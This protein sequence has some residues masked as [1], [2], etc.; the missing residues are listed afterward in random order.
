M[1]TVKDPEG[2]ASGVGSGDNTSRRSDL[3]AVLT[4]DVRGISSL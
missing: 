3:A 2:K 4:R 1:S